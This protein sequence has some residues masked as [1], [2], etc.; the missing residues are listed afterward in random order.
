V[1]AVRTVIPAYDRAT[2]VSECALPAILA[3]QRRA[4]MTDVADETIEQE[5]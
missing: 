5:T 3:Q 2:R 1:P 4:A